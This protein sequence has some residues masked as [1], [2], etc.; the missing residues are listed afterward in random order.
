M[1]SEKPNLNVV[2]PKIDHGGYGDVLK[3]LFPSVR[4]PF[5][6]PTKSDFSTWAYGLFLLGGDATDENMYGGFFAW[7]SDKEDLISS[8]LWQSKFLIPL[9][10]IFFYDYKNSFEYTL[11]FPA[12]VS[13]EYGLSHLDLFL[14]GHVFDG[15]S[16]NEFIPGFTLGFQYPYA[17][18]SAGLAFP[19]ERQAWGSDINRSAQQMR[20]SVQRLFA[21]GEV[22]LTGSAYVDRHN[23]DIPDFS[24]RGYEAISSRRALMV[25]TEYSHRLCRVRKGLWNPNVYFE[26]LYWTI[27]AD[28]ALTEEGTSPYSAGVELRL[29]TKVGFG[30]LYL[31]PRV[32]IAFTKS[33]EL[34]IFLGISPRLP[35]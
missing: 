15:I 21:G 20:L 34:K 7:D 23:P 13:L 9:D 1:P 31:V 25:S 6:L 3:T 33:R 29:E 19:F 24:I 16:R 27:F 32:G 26:D 11:T 5:V 28:C 12:F 8:I 10:V 18:L 22:C 17:T 35:I 2:E 14:T 4:V 30:F